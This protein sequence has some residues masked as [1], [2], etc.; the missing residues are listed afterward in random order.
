MTTFQAVLITFATGREQTRLSNS[1]PE[2]TE[3]T[4]YLG[5]KSLSV[6]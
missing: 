3:G 4:S 6:N 5:E 2:I 1:V